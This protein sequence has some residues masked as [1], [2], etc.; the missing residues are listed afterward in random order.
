[1][2]LRILG[3]RMVRVR[4]STVRIIKTVEVKVEVLET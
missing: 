2:K 4:A 3:A 1:L